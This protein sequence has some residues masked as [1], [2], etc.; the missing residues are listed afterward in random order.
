MVCWVI[1]KLLWNFVARSACGINKLLL[2]FGILL[3]SCWKYFFYFLSAEKIWRML[4]SC[5]PLLSHSPCWDVCSWVHCCDWVGLNEDWELCIRK[6]DPAKAYAILHM[7]NNPRDLS[8]H[9]E[10]KTRLLNM[11]VKCRWQEGWRKRSIDSSRKCLCPA[12]PQL[13]LALISHW[14]WCTIGK[15]FQADWR[16]KGPRKLL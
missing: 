2:N 10:M 12:L 7:R 5:S 16:G 14:L 15:R 6:K 11:L 4:G 3:L 9:S 1:W 13:R 8:E